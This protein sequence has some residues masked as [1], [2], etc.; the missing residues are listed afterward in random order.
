MGIVNSRAMTQLITKAEQE[1][2]VQVT[3][4]TVMSRK[5]RGFVSLNKVRFKEDGF[6][7]DLAYITKQVLAMGYPTEGV[8]AVYRNAMEEVVSFFEHYHN[9]KYRV[10]NLCAE[11][12]RQ[13]SNQHFKN[14]CFNYPFKDHNP[15]PLSIMQPFCE[16]VSKWLAETPDHVA[17]IHCKAGKGRTGLM[18][19][20]L[21]MYTGQ[22]R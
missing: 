2:I 5:L 7:L 18:I 21:L 15:P 3:T 14:R 20:A 22:C 17:A 6:D 1:P 16:D 19:C 12:N 9:D 11:P 13:Y 4:G 8:E 10:Y